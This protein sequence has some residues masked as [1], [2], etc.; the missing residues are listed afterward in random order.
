M[1]KKTRKHVKNWAV[2]LI[3]EPAVDRFYSIPFE[4]TGFGYDIFGGERECQLLTFA[5]GVWLYKNYFQ[6]ES[7]NIE[8][9]PSK[10][11]IIIAGNKLGLIPFETLMLFVDAIINHSPPRFVRLQTSRALA[12]FPFLGMFAQRMSRIVDNPRNMEI[13]LNREEP[14]LFQ[15]GEKENPIGFLFRKNYL[16]KFKTQ[17]IELCLRNK[18]PVLPVAFFRLEENLPLVNGIK[19][20]F[21]KTISAEL[22][23]TINYSILN[24]MRALPMPVKMFIDYGEP[25]SFF[26]EYP[27]ETVEH[28]NLIGQMADVVRERIQDIITEGLLVRQKGTNT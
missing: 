27:E 13:I 7:K 2:L 8:N 11:R 24:F 5:I 14:L 20:L 25:I 12:S 26:E 18:A 9:M 16:P 19:S 23:S 22:P 21:N 4:D 28:P 10:G 3:G 17:F 15:P 6:V 1:D